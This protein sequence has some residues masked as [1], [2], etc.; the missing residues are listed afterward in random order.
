ML[1]PIALLLVLTGPGTP[2]GDHGP[3]PDRGTRPPRQSVSLRGRV[4]VHGAVDVPVSYARLALY[5]DGRSVASTAT[6]RH[7]YFVMRD[8]L[9]K[10]TYRLVLETSDY[11][12]EIEVRIPG[13][14]PDVLLFARRLR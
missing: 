8:D 12:G 3:W 11:Q 10:G 1:A 9:G 5:H 6:D 4:V 2:P 7:G 13:E 14:T